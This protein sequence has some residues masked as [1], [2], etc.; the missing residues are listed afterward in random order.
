VLGTRSHLQQPK[1]APLVQEDEL[2]SL[3]GGVV[4]EHA[5]P[6][7]V[8]WLNTSASAKDKA[9]FVRAF[10]AVNHPLCGI[11]PAPAEDAASPEPNIALLRASA[12]HKPPA[13]PQLFALAGD[14][15][16]ARPCDRFPSAHTR[17]IDSRACA[18]TCA[19]CCYAAPHPQN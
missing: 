11:M 14:D 15:T 12:A 18:H 16:R 1:P 2:R 19:T 4:D 10:R 9:T 17:A 13:V 8:D 6:A 3:C 5:M 7:L